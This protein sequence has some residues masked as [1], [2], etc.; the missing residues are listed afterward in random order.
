MKLSYPVALALVGVYLIATATPCLADHAI[1]GDCPGRTEAQE[2]VALG[3][4]MARGYGY[5]TETMF[6]ELEGPMQW[7]TLIAK[8]YTAEIHP[9]Q[10]KKWKDALAG[11]CL[12][13]IYFGCEPAHRTSDGGFSGCIDY[14]PEL[15]LLIDSE[16]GKVLHSLRYTG[17][18]ARARIDE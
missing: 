11:R 18:D 15:W 4:S 2:V 1:Y 8:S 7:E 14:P 9:S 16:S 12:W 5:E 17:T 10:I 3:V 13:S 6:M